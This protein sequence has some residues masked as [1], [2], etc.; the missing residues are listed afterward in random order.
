MADGMAAPGPKGGDVPRVTFS[1][2]QIAG[3]L[4]DREVVVE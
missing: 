2:G 1:L 3:T 4:V